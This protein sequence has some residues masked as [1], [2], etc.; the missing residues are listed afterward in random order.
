M[1]LLT[2]WPTDTSSEILNSRMKEFNIKTIWWQ[3][4]GF[5]FFYNHV[6]CFSL[7]LVFVSS[8]TGLRTSHVTFTSVRLDWNPVPERFIIGY[9]VVVQNIP[10]IKTLSWNKTSDI[11]TGL[12]SNTRYTISVSP[13]HGLTGEENP[14]QSSA[15]IMVTTKQEPGKKNLKGLLFWHCIKISHINSR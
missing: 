8:L 14:V 9:R 6:T 11:I 2:V 4:K 10:L 3:E 13:V 15:N 7:A 12:R 1:F 5:Q